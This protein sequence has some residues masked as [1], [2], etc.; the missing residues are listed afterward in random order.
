MIDKTKDIWYNFFIRFSTY[1]FI[2]FLFPLKYQI[3]KEN[4][5]RSL[6]S[7][8]YE[9]GIYMINL[10]FLN[11][12]A[13]IK[14]SPIVSIILLTQIIIFSYCFFI[15]F[16]DHS[17]AQL[18]NK[19]FQEIYSKYTKYFI[20]SEGITLDHFERAS[21][22]KFNSIED[23]G[24]EE[25]EAL[26]DNLMEIEGL[27]TALLFQAQI[28][29]SEPLPGIELSEKTASGYSFYHSNSLQ[30]N[31]N[32]PYR[33]QLHTLAVDKN[34]VDLFDL[35]LDSGRSFTEEEFT[36][37]D[38]ENI[39]VLLGSD[40]KKIYSVGDT[41]KGSIF[42]GDKES[43]FKVIGFIAKGQ[44]Y[45]S[46]IS[47][48]VSILDNCI[49][50]PSIS[51]TL[52]QWIQLYEENND[53]FNSSR[54]VLDMY[55]HTLGTTGVYKTRYLLV[56]K[57][58][59]EV[60]VNTLNDIFDELSLTDPLILGGSVSDTIYRSAEFA[61][62]AI[63]GSV[64]VIVMTVLSI[65]SIV[66]SAVN[67]ITNNM[68]SYAIH[69]LI[70][71]TRT[72]ILSFSVFESFLYCIIGFSIGFLMEYAY[73]NKYEYTQHPAFDMMLKNSIPIAIL[74][75]FIACTLSLIFVYT[76]IRS[77]SVSELI[78]GREAKKSS[79]LPFYK[80]ITF[81]M[82]LCSSV[83][84]TFITSYN[85]QLE[86]TNKYQYDFSS[87]DG[88]AITI[89]PKAE[90]SPSVEFD[91]NV[92]GAENYSIDLRLG[93]IAD[94]YNK[95]NVRGWYK[96]GLMETPNILH[97]RFFT[98]EELSQTNNYA[99]VGQ[100]VYERFTKESDGKRFF[101][102]KGKNYEVIGVT[103]LE[104]QTTSIDEWVFITLPTAFKNYKEILNVTTIYVEGD[105]KHDYITATNYIKE[106]LESQF[107]Y[108]EFNLEPYIDIGLSKEVVNLFMALIFLTTSVFGIYYIDKI[109]N[110]INIKMFIGYSKPM[111]FADTIV[112]FIVISSLSFSIGNG[113]MLILS[114]TIF[115]DVA[116]F[117]A[118]HI[119]FPILIFSFGVMLLISFIFSVIAI[120][121][122]FRRSSR[123]LKK[124]Q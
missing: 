25:Y 28:N 107:I 109:N 15:I 111:I 55:A 49:I 21:G 57:G 24:F 17:Q 8:I 10:F 39:P 33:Y 11:L 60:F 66:F 18:N 98:D 82:F 118:Y 74:Y 16:F 30:N 37:L 120:N 64:L 22:Y 92:E 110:I 117:S 46:P 58:Q 2:I 43:T 91:F 6:F 59:E 67:N 13:N 112:Q 62:K 9:R 87:L 116:L 123:D 36:E 81:A 7:H 31:P 106:Q 26:Y 119:N 4:G 5:D 88:K 56:E 51:M 54:M 65:L 99:V 102:Y 29:R 86:H 95:I 108:M 42:F 75:I 70:G 100:T 79:R 63:V 96:K 52:E 101:E 19:S 80:W 12:W 45:M 85:W 47:S 94:P 34:Y 103:G 68:K 27:K 124:N 72:Q 61:E 113:I 1:K 105:S 77:Y 41:F 121:K 23:T 83:C 78:R 48:Y 73:I 20:G 53:Y 76:K 97:G 122:A 114:K 32:E 71:A 93:G 104:G 14:R 35:V 69:S 115:K 89:M 50:I 3:K 90:D 84:I 44:V 40:Y 38:L